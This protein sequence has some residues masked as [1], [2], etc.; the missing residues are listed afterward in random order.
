MPSAIT[1]RSR[2]QTSIHLIGGAVC[3]RQRH[4]GFNIC[5]RRGPLMVTPGGPLLVLVLVISAL[6][7]GGVDGCWGVGVPARQVC[8]VI[9]QLT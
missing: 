2:G 1:H 9:I 5:D 3:H 7:V 6:I 8:Q 4:H